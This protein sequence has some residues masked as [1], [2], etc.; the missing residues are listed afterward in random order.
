MDKKITLLYVDDEPINLMLFENIFSHKY[1]VLTAVTGESG[2]KLLNEHP[3]ISLI[4]S[5]M[6]MPFKTGLE[7]IS[8][9]KKKHPDKKYFI[10]TGYNITEEIQMALQAQLISKYFSKPFN[11]EEIKKTIEESI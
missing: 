7:F 9:A 5:D 8:E 11:I 10:I 1:Y 6:K 2:L 4:F 3:E